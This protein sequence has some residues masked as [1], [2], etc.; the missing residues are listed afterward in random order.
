MASLLLPHIK[1]YCTLYTLLHLVTAS[2]GFVWIYRD[3]STFTES[4]I[5]SV[6]NLVLDKIVLDNL[7]RTV[8][9][10]NDGICACFVGTYLGASSIYGLRMNEGQRAELIQSSL[11]LRDESQARSVLLEPG[12]CKALL[13]N[14]VQSWL[15]SSQKD[16]N[17]GNS[18]RLVTNSSNII[19]SSSSWSV[20][21][22]TDGGLESD[23]S[24]SDYDTVEI[25]SDD[26]HIMSEESSENDERESISHL[27]ELNS[28]E[29]ERMGRLS[30][31]KAQ[32]RQRAGTERLDQTEPHVLFFRIVQKMAQ[33]KIKT[34]VEALPRSKIENTGIA[35]AVAYGIQLA[36]RRSSKK[37]PLIEYVCAGIATISFG[38]ILSREAFL[39]NIHDKQTMQIVCKDLTLSIL[40]KMKEKSTSTKALFAMLF[41]V[42]VYRKRRTQVTRRISADYFKR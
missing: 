21:Q 38:T 2:L 22:A 12:G 5:R 39:G 16:K 15:R 10:P 35:A 8:Y 25:N 26:T 7:L 34:Y 40:N 24:T 19:D 20:H 42:I 28:F 3:L 37:L 41:L 14:F 1:E 27:N 4:T 30:E 11:G 36:L 32:E 9:D 33:T 18:A 23:K 17:K 6:L 29:D 31:P 13:P